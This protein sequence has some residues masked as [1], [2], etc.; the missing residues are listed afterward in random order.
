MAAVR[1]FDWSYEASMYA[2]TAAG[3][4]AVALLAAGLFVVVA[5]LLNGARRRQSERP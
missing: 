3:I 4:F 5:S 1:E 2:G